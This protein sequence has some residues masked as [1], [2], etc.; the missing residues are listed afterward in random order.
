MVIPLILYTIQQLIRLESVYGRHSRFTSLSQLREA[1]RREDEDNGLGEEERVESTLRPSP[2]HRSRF[3]SSKRLRK[4]SVTQSQTNLNVKRYNHKDETLFIPGEVR[5]PLSLS[6]WSLSS[7]TF[8][9][10]WMILIPKHACLQT[11][12]TDNSEPPMSTVYWGILDTGTNRYA[13]P[14]SECFP[15]C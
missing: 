2:S 5:F 4:S 11:E 10:R 14:A 8:D 1:Q 7:H 3:P 9:E 13:H 12:F 15:C 6:L